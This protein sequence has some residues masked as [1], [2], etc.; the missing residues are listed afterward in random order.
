MELQNRTESETLPIDAAKLSA[1]TENLLQDFYEPRETLPLWTFSLVEPD[2]IR[3]LN[4]RFRGV[5][6]VTDVLSF[7]ADFEIDPESGREYLGDLIVCVSRARDQA[8]D[9][10]HSLQDEISLLT[11]HGLLHLLGYDHGTPAEKAEM[12]KIQDEYIARNG[13]KLGKISGDE[14]LEDE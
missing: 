11:I 6:E 5:N 10:G 8:V 14:P 9:G 13:L 4:R 3:E 12:W 2:E 7:P 1:L